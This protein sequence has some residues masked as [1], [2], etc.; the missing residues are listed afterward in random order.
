MNKPFAFFL[1]SLI[2]ISAVNAQDAESQ[3][4]DMVGDTTLWQKF[5]SGM[6]EK[7]LKQAL[8]QEPITQGQ[9][10][11][12]DKSQNLLRAGVVPIINSDFNIIFEMMNIAKDRRLISVVLSTESPDSEYSGERKNCVTERMDLFNEIVSSMKEKYVL[13]QSNEKNAE[14]RSGNLYVKV[15]LQKAPI[16]RPTVSAETFSSE[17]LYSLY[18][19]KMAR[20]ELQKAHCLRSDIDASSSNF[21]KQLRLID[22]GQNLA[23]IK[24]YYTDIRALQNRNKYIE[25]EK[26]KKDLESSK[27]S[28]LS[29]VN[30]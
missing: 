8:K 14:F 13:I 22:G 9:R 5:T 4:Q 23:N 12:F 21:D 11:S 1:G 20:Y 16:I 24:I 29:K 15:S 10:F 18:K 25:I 3:V 27:K 7:T 6:D 30:L 2:S 26:Q 17:P 28:E 19:I